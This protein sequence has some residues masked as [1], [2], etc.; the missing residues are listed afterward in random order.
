M[1][2]EEE[3]ERRRHIKGGRGTDTHRS[4]NLRHIHKT[5]EIPKVL[6][7]RNK[8]LGTRREFE[9]IF[10]G[11]EVSVVISTII[12]ITVVGIETY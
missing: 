6:P 10:V 8:K 2:R 4:G 1:M 11:I 9:V 3:N 5:R 12:G 7:R